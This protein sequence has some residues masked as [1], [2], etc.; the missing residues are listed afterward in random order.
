MSKQRTLLDH[1]I[2]ER[3]ARQLEQILNVAGA[4]PVTS[5]DACKSQVRSPDIPQYL[6]LDGI[7][8]GCREAATFGELG[9]ITIRSEAKSNQVEQMLRDRVV[10]GCFEL[11]P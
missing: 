7:E 4:Q 1:E 8:A 3:R 9:C 6:G 10:G 5:G 11:R 2:R